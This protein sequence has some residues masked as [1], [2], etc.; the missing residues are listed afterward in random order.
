MLELKAMSSHF[1]VLQAGRVCCRYS[2]VL[3][4]LSLALLSSCRQSA[5]IQIRVSLYLLSKIEN[6]HVPQ[7]PFAMYAILH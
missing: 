1:T 3:L 4:D 5:K 6:V 7:L 2:F